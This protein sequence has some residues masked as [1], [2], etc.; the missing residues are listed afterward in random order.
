MSVPNP[1]RGGLWRQRSKNAIR[2]MLMTWMDSTGKVVCPALSE[3]D[4]AEIM[5]L[6]SKAYPF[7]ERAMYPYKAWL[8]EVKWLR[9][10]LYRTKPLDP[11]EPELEGLFA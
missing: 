11:V 10:Q 7:G 9:H 1:G 8:A 4:K 2:E 3:E 5:R 6:V